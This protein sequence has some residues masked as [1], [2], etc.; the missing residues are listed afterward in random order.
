MSRDRTSV[1]ARK[2]SSFAT[3]GTNCTIAPGMTSSYRAQ[4][5]PVHNKY[6][7]TKRAIE[8]LC[9]ARARELKKHIQAE[10]DATASVQD[11]RA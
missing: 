5:G 9:K 3:V 7:E 6:K 11:I 2:S 1:D 10:Y 8:Q 4:G